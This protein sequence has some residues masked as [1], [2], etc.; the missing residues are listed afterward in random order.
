MEEGSK[1]EGSNSNAYLDPLRVLV[2]LVPFVPNRVDVLK[3]LRALW[4]ARLE[5]S[6]FLGVANAKNGEEI[7]SAAGNPCISE[8]NVMARVLEAEAAFLEKKQNDDE[9]A[10]FGNSSGNDSG[11]MNTVVATSETPIE[12]VCGFPTRCLHGT[13]SIRYLVAA[14]IESSFLFSPTIP[15]TLLRSWCCSTI[16]V[17]ADYWLLP[18]IQHMSFVRYGMDLS[19]QE[20]T[21]SALCKPHRNAKVPKILFLLALCDPNHRFSRYDIVMEQAQQWFFEG[22]QAKNVNSWL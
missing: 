8:E 22:T 12:R 20:L 13:T 14:G 5:K 9:A 11:E 6:G 10:I 17:L 1:A 4:L 18:M 2:A 7:V 3:L 21:L 16:L 19:V 15:P